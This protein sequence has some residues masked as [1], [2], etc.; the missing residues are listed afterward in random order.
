MGL[1][2]SEIKLHSKT[3]WNEWLRHSKMSIQAQRLYKAMQ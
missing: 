3:G 1:G 2:D